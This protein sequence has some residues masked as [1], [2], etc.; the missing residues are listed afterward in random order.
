[1]WGT[2]CRHK[3]KWCHC[4]LYSPPEEHKRGKEKDN[5]QW[6]TWGRAFVIQ[7]QN[8]TGTVWKATKEKCLGLDGELTFTLKVSSRLEFNVNSFFHLLGKGKT[9]TSKILSRKVGYRM[10]CNIFHICLK[11]ITP[12]PP[13]L[14]PVL[15]TCISDY[16]SESL[17]HDVLTSATGVQTL[18]KTSHWMPDKMAFCHVFMT[19]GCRSIYI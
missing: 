8:N 16:Q 13:H 9:L 3:P 15:W 17:A 11:V 6:S 12:T 19:S 18:L 10:L 1:M 5:S 2:T 4:N 7:N 14:P